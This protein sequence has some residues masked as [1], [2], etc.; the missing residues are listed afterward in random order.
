[1]VAIFINRNSSVYLVSC[2][3]SEFV[4]RFTLF[5]WALTHEWGTFMHLIW[6][7]IYCMCLMTYLLSLDRVTK[8]TNL[9]MIFTVVLILF[10]IIMA[11][12]CKW[13]DGDVTFLYISYKYIIVLI[14]CCIVSTFIKWGNI[15]GTMD[16]FSAGIRDI[17]SINGYCVFC[18]YTDE[19]AQ[20]GK[21]RRR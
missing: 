2:L 8:K 5:S 15:I 4:G 11:L 19:N 21:S 3:L 9:T 7:V 16:E 18:W 12:D 14:H 1:M 20:T 17:I 6:S 13:S 10:Q